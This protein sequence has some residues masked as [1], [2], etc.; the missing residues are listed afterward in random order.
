[1]KS[2]ICVFCSRQPVDKNKEHVLGRWL[3]SKTGDP[4]RVVTFGYNYVLDKKISFDW[5]SFTVP[6]C[7]K[8]NTEY[9]KLETNTIPIISKLEDRKELTGT[10]LL[11]LLDWLDKVR[12]GLWLNYY[13]LQKNI[14]G[15]KPH[16]AIDDRL[17]KKDRFLQIYFFG[18]KNEN[19]G[20]NAIGV[21]TPAF[22]FNPSVFGLR[23]NNVFL[24]NGSNDFVASET[25]GFPFPRYIQPLKDQNGMLSLSDWFYNREPN[26]NSFSLK[27]PKPVLA[28]FQPIQ[29]EVDF[30]DHFFKDSYVFTR[31]ID[32]SNRIGTLFIVRSGIVEPIF[33]SNLESRIF[34][35]PVIG[36]NVTTQGEL[37]TEVYRA[38]NVF[39]LSYEYPDEVHEVYNSA[40]DLNEK[41]IEYLEKYRG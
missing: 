8:C 29:T 5:D 31:C 6:S 32:I 39:L 34:Y 7:T 28:I 12:I 36:K 9:S 13:F 33:V 38:Q 1:M 21:E 18:S 2:K 22:Q 37:I 24:F 26:L 23:I 25:C 19:R 14:G 30:A 15:I 11:T 16:M 20:L 4:N 40:I 3:I 27:L 10:E 17:G 41:Y 35:E